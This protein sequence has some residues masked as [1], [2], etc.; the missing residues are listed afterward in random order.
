MI[1]CSLKYENNPEGRK[2][3]LNA[4]QL[5]QPITGKLTLGKENEDKEYITAYL[6][7]YPTK[8]NKTK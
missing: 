7:L 8:T 4:I 5:L 2:E 6:K 3:V 1:R